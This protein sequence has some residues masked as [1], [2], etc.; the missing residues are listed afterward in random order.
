MII[1]RRFFGGGD[2]RKQTLR[3]GDTEKKIPLCLSV[4]VL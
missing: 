4:S 3:R 1:G 2:I